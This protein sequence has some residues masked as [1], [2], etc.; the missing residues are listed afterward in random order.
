MLNISFQNSRA[1]C[2]FT[3]LSPKG[4]TLYKEDDCKK[5]FFFICQHKITEKRRSKRN[6]ETSINKKFLE[7]AYNK[8]NSSVQ[9]VEQEAEQITMKEPA[10]VVKA[11][12]GAK[13]FM[14]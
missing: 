1:F 4:T 8:A 14:K 9:S 6:S 7:R 5:K 3:M 11:T 10:K 13:S 12:N 2:P